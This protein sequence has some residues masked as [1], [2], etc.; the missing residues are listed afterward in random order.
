MSVDT[1][2]QEIDH[3]ELAALIERVE[4]A[5]EHELSLSM[6]DLKLL[7]CAITT[8][9]TLQEKIEQNDVTL[10][11]LRKLLGMVRQSE[12][13]RQSKKRPTDP[14]KKGSNKTN[15]KKTPKKKTPPKVMHHKIIQYSIGQT[16]PLCTRGKLYKYSPGTLLRITGHS[17]YEATQHIREQFRCNTCHYV[18]K[19]DLPETVLEDGAFNQK[20]GYSA[21][22]IMV[23]GKFYSGLPYYHQGNLSDIFGC[24][25]SASTI[26]DQCEQVSN[27]VMPVFYEFIRQ[28]A[29]AELFLVDDTRN[30]ILSQ[31]PK[32]KPNP[33]GK[34]QRLRTGVYSS[35]LIAVL[36]TGNEIVLFETSLGHAGEHLDKI[37]QKRNPE[38]EQP[39]VMADALSS[40]R[41]TKTPFHE[42]NCNAHGRREFFDLQAHH[43]KD[44]EWVL[45]TYS[46][47]WKIEDEVK[48]RG[49][50]DQE[51]LAYHK[52][53]SLPEI[54]KIRDWAIQKKTSK[55]FEAN[56]PLGKAINYFLR[57]YKKLILFCLVAGAP[58]D[59]NRMEEKLKIVIRGRK[60]A[61]FYKTIIG[62]GV[63]NVLIS[64]I[65]TAHSAGI[66]L[67]H[68][69]TALQRY[70][71]EV[72]QD[73]VNWLPWNYE[74][75]IDNL[76]TKKLK[77]DKAA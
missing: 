9:C 32:M 42:A 3:K 34:G 46:K 19:A 31:Q 67:F 41:V 27:A 37:L 74:K 13:R 71:K 54:E 45:E 75:T 70:Q 29:N 30:R 11:K 1:K 65:A 16:C 64:L 15:T 6:E 39:I 33:S 35:G 5:I 66:N 24:A 18:Y 8:L 47:I 4:Y 43:P 59:N 2:L 12:S 72:S 21:R 20:Y 68:Y 52:E 25:I 63:A 56:S 73:P 61:H 38:L 36:K 14:N 10:Y 51:R 57:H 58:I 17:P 23:L 55:T 48:K 62:A 28:A 7:L 26:F 77:P 53:H 40:N 69:F 22:S 60:T 50:N 76:A 44:I 49:L